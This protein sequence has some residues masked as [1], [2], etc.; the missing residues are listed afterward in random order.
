MSTDVTT[1]GGTM[2]AA[3]RSKYGP[4]DVVRLASVAKPAVTAD[5]VLVRVRAASVN[6]ADCY[7]V[8][9][10]PY[11]GRPQWGLRA[12]KSALI[13]IDFAGTVEAVGESVTQFRPGDAVFGGWSGTFAEYVCV[14]QDRGI[15]PKPDNL[16]FEEAAA[17]PVAA[18]T[19]L[20]GLRDRGRLQAGQSVLVNGAS[21]AVGVFGVQI[22]KALGATV[23]AVCSTPHVDLVRSIGA[24]HVVDYTREDFTRRDD[25]HDL[26]LD[27][28]GSRSW[29]ECSRVLAPNGVLVIVGGPSRGKL[30]GPLRHIAAL[31]LGAVRSGRRVAFFIAR[32][33]KPDMLALHDLLESEKVKPVVERTYGLSD[34]VEALRYV[35]AGHSNAKTVITI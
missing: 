22:V 20:Q 3:V 4:P 15:A 9:G 27:I 5:G 11:L 18:T 34:I 6:R 10:T 2:T 35:G 28:A 24:D 19:A 23:T 29:S 17:V 1:G 33:T 30:I 21:G 12:P 31:R 32:L 16:T 8:M 7:S 14:P 25:R 26:L 13:G